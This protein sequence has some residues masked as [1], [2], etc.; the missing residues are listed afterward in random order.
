MLYSDSVIEVMSLEADIVQRVHA[1]FAPEN[2]AS[3]LEQLSRSPKTGRIARCIVAGAGGSPERL[4]YL[5]GLADIDYRDVIV[6]GEYDGSMRHVRDLRV[7][8][9]IDS[10]DDS[11]I[12]ETAAAIYK[13]G[14]LLTGV[15]SRA[16]EQGPFEYTCD[17]SEGVATFSDG[18]HVIAIQKKNGQWSLVE[19]GRDLHRFGLDAP[20]EDDQR[21]RVQLDFYLKEISTHSHS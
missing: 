13:R 10:P 11:W 8:F 19:G 3:V 14:Y 2:V 7:S 12:G 15:K 5:I 20:I 21:F 1:D 6:A 18:A 16:A 17:R 9:L 4:E